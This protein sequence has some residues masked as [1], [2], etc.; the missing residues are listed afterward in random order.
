VSGQHQLWI[1]PVGLFYTRKTTFR[2]AVL[3]IFG[4]PIPVP[5]APPGPDGEPP[6]DLVDE[7]TEAV[8][9]G[10]AR[11]VAQAD[12]RSA[13]ELASR[14][15]RLLDPAAPGALS[16]R[17]ALRQRLLA[18]YRVLRDQ[19]P[20]E[21]E[22]ILHRI[23]QLD[24]AFRR[25]DVEPA[26]TASGRFTPATVTAASLAF[27]LRLVAFLPLAIPGIILHYPGYRLIGALAR[28]VAGSN[29][30]VLATAKIIGAAIVFPATWLALGVFAGLAFDW[31]VGLFAALVAPFAGYAGLRLVERFDRFLTAARAF[32]FYLFEREQFSMLV[33]AREALRADLLSL[34]ER[35]RI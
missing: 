22:R 11:L 5:C 15:E 2:S 17:L 12:E 31:K 24:A 34:A 16:T 21:L 18:G 33:S 14:A 20:A 8:E 29:D 1:V 7:L 19:A 35:Y 6:P 3:T 28:R 13:L 10:L 26:D 25:A 23:E 9:V 27:A 32:G 4:Q 30:D